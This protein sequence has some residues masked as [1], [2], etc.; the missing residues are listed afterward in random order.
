MIP[1]QKPSSHL[2]NPGKA[3]K[4]HAVERRKVTVPPDHQEPIL[5]AATAVVTMGISSL[6]A[7]EAAVI[8]IPGTAKNM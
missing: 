6:Q 4:V 5:R 7:K 8:I 2:K 1:V 3:K